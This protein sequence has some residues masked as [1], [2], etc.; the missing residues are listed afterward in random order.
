M[1]KP[2]REIER[3]QRRDALK[4]LKR[5]MREPV[6][7]TAR[8]RM[9]WWYNPAMLVLSVWWGLTGKSPDA[10]TLLWLIRRAAVVEHAISEG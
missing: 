9:R 10:R 4:E 2:A 3:R 1:S 5:R 7:A 8:T 6:T